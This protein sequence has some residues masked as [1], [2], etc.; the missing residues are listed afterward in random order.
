MNR[1]LD[2]LWRMNRR[3]AEETICVLHVVHACAYSRNPTPAEIIA[4]D[5]LPQTMIRTAQRAINDFT[6]R[7]GQFN[8]D[9]PAW[10]LGIDTTPE[11]P[12]IP[13][14]EPGADDG[15]TTH[16]CVPEDL[17]YDGHYAAPGIGIAMHCGICSKAWSKI[18]DQYH[19][20]ESMAHIGTIDDFR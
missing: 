4:Y 5:Q 7:G 14:D 19:E 3:D 12:S 6:S 13:S 15:S 16:V 10:Q 17:I 1:H 18:G 11:G 8:I 20:A 9:H 2:T